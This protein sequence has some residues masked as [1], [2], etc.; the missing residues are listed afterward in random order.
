M[1]HNPTNNLQKVFIVI[2][3]VLL[4]VIRSFA[5]ET[6]GSLDA[7]SK[8][9]L[10]RA[11]ISH[12]IASLPRCGDGQ[13]ALAIVR[14]SGMVVHALDANSKNTEALR[15]LADAEGWLARRLYVEA[16]TAE[17][18][19]Y[20][21]NFVDMI[22]YSNMADADLAG[23]PTKEIVRVLA[24]FRGVVFVGCPKP[25]VADGKL[26][27]AALDVWAKSLGLPD[28]K[29]WDDETGLWAMAR[30]SALPGSESWTHRYHGADN[31]PASGDTTIKVPLLTQWMGLPM[32]E[33]WWGTA[34][35]GGGGRIFTIW[36]ERATGLIAPEITEHSLTARSVYNGS[37]L[38]ERVLT[39]NVALDKKEKILSNQPTINYDAARC[40]MVA[41][42][43]KLHLIDGDGVL[44][45]DAET[46]AE[47]GRINGPQAGGQIKWIALTDGILAILVGEPDTITFKEKVS[48]MFPIEPSGT[49][50]A[51]YDVGTGH[52]LWRKQAKSSIDE[53]M[54]ALNNGKLFAY[55]AATEAFCLELKTGKSLW[56]NSDPSLLAGV[57]TTGASSRTDNVFFPTRGIIATDKGIVLGMVWSS[58]VVVLSPETG[59][60]QCDLPISGSH[61]LH[62]YVLDG[63]WW[64]D[65][66]RM[67]MATGK[68][69]GG[70]RL[71]SDS[72]GPS[73]ATP[74]FQIGGFGKI[75]DMSNGKLLTRSDLK[76]PCDLGAIVSDG[77]IVS[78]PSQCVCPME[79]CG[80][81]ALATTTQDIS[82]IPNASSRLMTGSTEPPGALAI[83]AADWPTYRANIAR[84]GATTV[85][86]TSTMPHERWRWSPAKP[87]KFDPSTL[88]NL[89]RPRT[90]TN[91][92]FAA[93]PPVAA[94]GKIWIGN[95]EGVVCCLDAASG[96]PIW[97]FATA[98]CLFAPPT[99]AD[100][101][102][103]AGSGDGW[104]YC[105]DATSGRE[106][107]R[108]RAAP[109]E[110]KILW[111]GH[112]I[113]TWPVLTGVIVHEGVA[114]AAAGH[115]IINGV[116]VYALDAA[117][118]RVLWE[119]RD[120]SQLDSASGG[121][122]AAG[123]MAVGHGKL[124]LTGSI[125]WPVS[126]DL[127]TGQLDPTP[128]RSLGWLQ[129]T[130]GSEI[131]I[132]ADRF[133]LY[134]GKRLMSGYDERLGS[135]RGTGF[136]FV[137]LKDMNSKT[138][139]VLVLPQTTL[140]LV[141]DADLI[142]GARDLNRH[143][144]GWT[145]SKLTTY[146]DETIAQAKDSVIKSGKP[147]PL[148]APETKVADLVRM[149][150]WEVP[151]HDDFS[152]TTLT[153]NA[154]LAVQSGPQGKNALPT[155]KLV[156]FDRKNGALLWTVPLP[157]EPIFNGLCV[158]RDGQILVV[159]RDG[160]ML[161]YGKT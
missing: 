53:R 47:L 89:N 63:T 110:R 107:W 96:K 161:C 130:R 80:Y 40:C 16:G 131:G 78:T 95:A 56:S 6:D 52:E 115:H 140:P 46:G 120:S 151:G 98:A 141:W 58:K 21:D 32:H 30:K 129:A 71:V 41:D 97:S 3:T 147:A 91:P 88:I 33:G 1:K 70:D 72:C 48:M 51:A 24:P 159:L 126:F 99:L 75:K 5:A 12:G 135:S 101:R 13:L 124:W 119:N 132:F 69:L 105:L 102:I 82:K 20:A 22:I 27:K 111:Y 59:A 74:N 15:I 7:L 62:G 65:L 114:Y 100:G 118:G 64:S 26:T 86:V 148:D 42:G 11:G 142:V 29:V 14:H 125:D 50:L 92:Q 108:F 81:R 139:K 112:L 31:N 93:T 44:T 35:V 150:A 17:L 160:G 73:T 113:N 116:Y 136:A 39:G 55:A 143:L 154:F 134:G 104:I 83:T 60:V 23:L 38:W 57:N 133:I 122:G 94:A 121:N 128:T 146:L 157:C 68:R 18:L 2:A 106:L 67:D 153:A 49:L 127:K 117:S 138:S 36:F 123:T 137:D 158:D 149:Q 4:T 43:S 144:S 19:P 61:T 152:A 90:T 76:S 79:N 103:F 25:N 34:F 109:L 37:V 155:W 87:V 10:S 145:S 156:A 77:I 66:G 84:T 45:L 8:T 85:N 9:L 28:C 54:L